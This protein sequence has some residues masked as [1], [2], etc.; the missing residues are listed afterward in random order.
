M[1][2]CRLHS[3]VHAVNVDRIP[4]CN[5]KRDF[6]FWGCANHSVIALS[7]GTEKGPQLR[8]AGGFPL[9][10]AEIRPIFQNLNW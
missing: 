2:I 10:R 8:R 3:H 9:G 1:L 4:L 5:M 7:N 6:V